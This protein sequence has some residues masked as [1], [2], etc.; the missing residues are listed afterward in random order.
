LEEAE[1]AAAELPV[2]EDRQPSKKSRF[3]RTAEVSPKAAIL[4]TRTDLEA[5]LNDFIQDSPEAYRQ[6]GAE[7]ARRPLNLTQ[8]VRVLRS[9]GAIDPGTSALLDDLRVMDNRAAQ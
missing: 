5:F 4:G 3:E 9:K 1:K 6:L 8:A 7:S 2:D